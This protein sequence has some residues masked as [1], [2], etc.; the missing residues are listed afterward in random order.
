M[1]RITDRQHPKCLYN[2]S[3]LLPKFGKSL[4]IGNS[5]NNGDYQH[6]EK[7]AKSID[8]INCNRVLEG[9]K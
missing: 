2:K 7:R 1:G 4:N 3:V 8:F 9:F 6:K 5:D